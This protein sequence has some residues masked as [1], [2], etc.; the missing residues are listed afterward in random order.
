MFTANINWF[1]HIS[2]FF[3]KECF[4]KPFFAFSFHKAENS[5]GLG[6]VVAKQYEFL[7]TEYY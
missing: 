5:S 4:I 7:H 6:E 2:Y 1:E 3:L